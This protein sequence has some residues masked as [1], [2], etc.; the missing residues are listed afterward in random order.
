VDVGAM[1]E[2][3]PNVKLSSTGGTLSNNPILLDSLKTEEQKYRNDI[4]V[5]RYYPVVDL[6]LL[7]RF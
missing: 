4:D 2:G 7:W 6:A 5:L 1:F 3:D